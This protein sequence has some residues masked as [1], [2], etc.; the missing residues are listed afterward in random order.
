VLTQGTDELSQVFRYG[1]NGIL[2]TAVHF[3]VLAFL[4]EGLTFSSAALASVLAATVGI[5]V[6]FFGNRYFVFKSTVDSVFRQARRFGLLYVAI[7]FVHAGVMFVISDLG[8]FSYQIGFAAATV[9]QIVLS[10]FGNR[11]LVFQ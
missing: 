11:F 9:V 5:A 4:I 1:I 10:Y 2:A 3:G 7:A 8:G 6:S